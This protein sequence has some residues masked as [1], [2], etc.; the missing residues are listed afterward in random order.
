MTKIKHEIVECIQDIASLEEELSE[1]KHRLKE[2][3]L[4]EMENIA[5][6][7]NI[8]RIELDR[9]FTQYRCDKKLVG[10]VAIDKLR[11]LYEDHISSKR[12]IWTQK[13]RWE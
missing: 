11:H 8:E 2:Y 12:K 1:I 5:I 13:T 3:L 6:S 4:G 10:S 9:L 7:R